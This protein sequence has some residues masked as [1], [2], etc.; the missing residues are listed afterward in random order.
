MPTNGKKPKAFDLDKFSQRLE[1]IGKDESKLTSSEALDAL[2]DAFV[3]DDKNC[4]P[5]SRLYNR[6]YRILKFDEMCFFHMILN[7]RKMEKNKGNVGN[8]DV[9]WL[10]TLNSK[11]V[12]RLLEAIQQYPTLE[13]GWFQLSEKRLIRE[14]RS[15]RDVETRVIESLREKG[16]ILSFVCG[17]PRKRWIRIN[18][19]RFLKLARSPNCG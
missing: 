7:I 16:L 1:R 15:T 6:L 11:A 17:M 5:Y 9:K 18:M 8:C 14:L 4:F 13:R 12:K 19:K 10:Q 2:E 3:G